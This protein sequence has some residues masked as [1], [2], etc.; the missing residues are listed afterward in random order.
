MTKRPD[1]CET[2][3]CWQRINARGG[4]QGECHFFP[5]HPEHGWSITREND[6][7]EQHK[8]KESTS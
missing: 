2:C 4:S 3:R 1:R 6:S 8:T 7:C 5:P